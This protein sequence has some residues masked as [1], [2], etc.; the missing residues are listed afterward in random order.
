MLNFLKDVLLD[1]TFITVG[2]GATAFGAIS[3][4]L[5]TFAV[6]RKQSL[7][8]DAISHA[9]LPGI[10]IMFLLTGT[11]STPLF[12]IGALISGIVA[13]V[14]VMYITK[15]SKVK[16][17]S[18]LGMILSV[19][20][21]LGL[22][23]LTYIQKI[24]NANQAG[25]DKFLFGQAST[26]LK[27]DVKIMGAVAIIVIIIT[28]LLWKE[29]K[30]LCFNSEFGA[31]LGLP[32]KKLDFLLTC[33]LV[34]SIV[35]GLQ[36]VGVILMSAMII[37]PAVAARQWTDKLWLMTVLSAIFGSVSGISGTLV[38]FFIPKMPTGPVIV[39]IMSCIVFISI[40]FAPSRGVIWNKIKNR[41][42]KETVN[43]KEH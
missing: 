31:S 35:M 40:L 27:I 2:L 21:G 23:L 24:P 39:I 28:S 4:I 22:V 25:L 6:L 1:H 13:S 26:L 16:Y 3:G 8:G 30:I 9:T 5:G 41:K 18:S 12:L 37:A 10:C 43:K 17:D 36:T 15:V 29:F 42:N 32:M 34:L 38:S 7:I 14:I 33:L 20:F 19:F 11:K